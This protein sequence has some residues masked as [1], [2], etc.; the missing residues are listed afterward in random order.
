MELTEA[1]KILI[2]NLVQNDNI[3]QVDVINSLNYY[4]QEDVISPV[5]V[6]N[7]RISMRDGYTFKSIDNCNNYILKDKFVFPGDNNLIKEDNSVCVYIATGGI[8]PEYCDTV[9]MVENV[10]IVNENFIVI[11]GTIKKEQW[12]RQVGSD[13]EKDT[14][15][16]KKGH[17]LNPSSIATLISLGIKSIKVYNKPKIG[18]LS[19]GDELIDQSEIKE[20]NKIYDINRP[21]LI[22]L[23][24]DYE[25]IDYKILNDNYEIC[26]KRILEIL[27]SVDILIT[28]GGISMGK[29]DYIKPIMNDLGTVYIDKLNMK[30]GKPFV[31]SKIDNKYI[32]SLPGNPISTYVTLLLLVKPSIEYF[33]GNNWTQPIKLSGIL[34]NDIKADSNRL[35]YLRGKIYRSDKY[36]K[37]FVDTTV[38]NSS[39]ISDTIDS[40]CLVEVLPNKNLNSGQNVNFYLINNIYSN[41]DDIYNIGIITTSDR[42]SNGVYSDI[43]GMEIK[44]YLKEELCNYNIYYSLIPDEQQQIENTLKNMCDNLCCNLI[45]TTGGTGPAL[46]DVTDL[47]TM[48]VCHKLLPGFGE[49]MRLRNFDKIPTSILSAQTAGIRYIYNDI[50][51][52]IINLPGKPEAIKEC[53]DIIFVCFSK[54][55]EL[56]KAGDNI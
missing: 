52:L 48:K 22:N 6:P 4:L 18:I 20:N 30:P 19:T 53:L 37:L 9:E 16:L 28:S 21:L 5:N 46:R 43:S 13:I 11:N 36:N 55:F 47:A 33:S 1:K 44:N 7:N 3:I 56:I 10:T 32:F 24:K 12:V 17:K 15:I 41:D 8:L 25:V 29:K 35:E 54:C 39:T 23:L 45:L 27:E 42:A 34:R 31:F 51:T 40:N 14:K 38:S 49:I 50:G 26:K 2:D